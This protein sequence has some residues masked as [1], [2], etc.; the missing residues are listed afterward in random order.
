MQGGGAGR[1]RAHPVT[2]RPL[3]LALVAGVVLAASA[4]AVAVRRPPPLFAESGVLTVGARGPVV[5]AL[6]REL[7]R[8]AIRVALDGRF[9]P[10]TR[11]AVAVLQHRLRIRVNGVV[12]R[13]LLWWLGISVCDLPGPTTAREAARGR[14]RL[15]AYGPAVCAL[16]RAL[17][18]AGF[19]VTI[20]GGFGPGTRAAVRAAQ[21]RAGLLP[22]GVS[23]PALLAR[24]RR[25]PGVPVAASRGPLP[26]GARGPRVR[27]LQI[28]LMRNGARLAVDGVYGRAT[29]RALRRVQ[30]R[31][32]MR[33]DGRATPAVMRRLGADAPPR[34][35]AFP[36]AGVHAF[37]ND[38][39][40]PRH[41]GP[42]EGNYILAPR[43]AAVVAVVDGT[44]SR[45]NRRE[46]GLGGVWIW[47]RGDDGT[48]YYYAHLSRIAARIGPGARVHAGELIGAVGM[49]GDARGTAP[50]LHFEIHP[51][52]GR[53]TNPFPDLVAAD[54]A[55][56]GRGG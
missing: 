40:A 56:A 5:R 27:D 26:A 55:R 29:A 32:G 15:G 33:P 50:H 24:L 47:L 7:R 30:R 34:L 19:P 49:T 46:S 4:D 21:R 43:G 18:R 22:T 48:G 28:A 17:V 10:A 39:G 14:L 42:H 44:I 9:G 3:I 53:A 38:F 41:Q 51:H 35:R 52:G 8:R 25:G 54:S 6:Q 11:R 23:S 31:L 13:P 1:R 12:D 20:D 36:V 2:V 45:A 37:S 16:Q